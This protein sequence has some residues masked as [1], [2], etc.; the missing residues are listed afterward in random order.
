MTES[1][2]KFENV[3]FMGQQIQVTKD[4]PHYVALKPL[5]EG[6]GMEKEWKGIHKQILADKVLMSTVEN[7][8]WLAKDGKMREMMCLPMKKK[9]DCSK[10]GKRRN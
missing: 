7:F 3:P 10:Q 9:S 1:I 6:M 4:E 5:F 8:R 2:M